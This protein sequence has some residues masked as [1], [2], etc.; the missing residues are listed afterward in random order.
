MPQRNGYKSH[1]GRSAVA[2]RVMMSGFSSNGMM[3]VNQVVWGV[4]NR[5]RLVRFTGTQAA[6]YGGPTKGGSAPSATG[7][8]VPPSSS[9]IPY[10]AFPMLDSVC[11]PR[12]EGNRCIPPWNA[13]GGSNALSTYRMN[14][15]LSGPAG[16]GPL[17]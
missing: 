10:G 12:V 2:R 4:N 9:Y 14:F 5:N 3:P 13:A 17:M 6:N 8:M 11:A 16:G 1:H 15:S 7:F